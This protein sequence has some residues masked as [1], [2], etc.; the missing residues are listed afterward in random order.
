MPSESRYRWHFF[1]AADE[2]GLKS[3]DLYTVEICMTGLDWARARKFFCGPDN[4]GDSAG[5][6]MTGIGNV[7]SPALVCDYAFD[8]CGYSMNGVSED[9]YSTVHVT[10]RGWVQLREL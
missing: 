6:E 9:R 2:G 8:P 1:A 3:D 4:S 5:R 10:S 7:V